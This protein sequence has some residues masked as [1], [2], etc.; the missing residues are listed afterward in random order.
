MDLT[1]FRISKGYN[2]NICRKCE[3]KQKNIRNFQ[4]KYKI[5]KNYFNGKCRDCETNYLN[6][7]A[8]E[9]HHPDL[10]KKTT[11]WRKLKGQSY[12]NI[13]SRL[14]YDKVQL[15]CRNC[16][17]LAGATTFK[18]YKEIIL[19]Y[20]FP[21]NDINKN[22]ILDSINNELHQFHLD[23]KF[24]NKTK[25]HILKWIKKKSLIELLY[26]G[27]CVGCEKTN[28]ENNLPA[29]IF[30]HLDQFKKDKISRWQKIS[31]LS[32][33]EIIN[34][35]KKEKCVC[36]CANCHKFIES[37]QFLEQQNLIIGERNALEVKRT[38]NLIIS[39]IENFNII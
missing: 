1:H 28:I 19:K 11:T 2:S 23:E 31:N 29:L 10:S 36:L 9:F 30:H 13:L 38:F 4:I 12:S 33:Q 22:N 27:S 17:T 18:F 14:L 3:L 26:K 7:P 25:Y 34:L 39:R 35:L 32:I 20:D 8:L 15:L 21:L 24:N 37:I 6:L 16:H 5:I